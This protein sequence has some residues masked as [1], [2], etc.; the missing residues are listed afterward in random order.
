MTI[1]TLSDVVSNIQAQ[2]KTGVTYSVA[3]STSRIGQW[4][5]LR[6]G[7]VVRSFV[8]PSGGTPPAAAGTGLWAGAVT[9]ANPIG[10]LIE[11]TDANGVS[12]KTDAVQF[13]QSL[14]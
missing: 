12:Q 6:N 4:D 8:F 1:K 9:D 2:S 10:T 7:V 5:I 14:N 13:I 11:L 3:A